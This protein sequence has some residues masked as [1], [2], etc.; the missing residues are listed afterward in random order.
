MIKKSDCWQDKDVYYAVIDTPQG[1]IWRL[2]S[3][4]CELTKDAMI[5]Q[6]IDFFPGAINVRNLDNWGTAYSLSQSLIEP[7]TAV[8]KQ[9]SDQF[10]S[11]QQLDETEKAGLYRDLMSELELNFE[12]AIFSEDNRIKPTL[13]GNLYNAIK[14]A[15]DLAHLQETS[16][17]Y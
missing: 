7:P 13:E 6:I 14:A 16:T 3:F 5:K 11:I 1:A 9:I 17:L 12:Q 2:F 15:R 10:H 4:D 8:L